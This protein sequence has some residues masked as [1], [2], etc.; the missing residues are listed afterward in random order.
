MSPAPACECDTGI[1]HFTLLLLLLVAIAAGCLCPSYCYLYD[2]GGLVLVLKSQQE[3][4]SVTC[5]GLP[6][7]WVHHRSGADASK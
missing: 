1:L 6:H 7:T 2:A 3:V 5:C 4:F